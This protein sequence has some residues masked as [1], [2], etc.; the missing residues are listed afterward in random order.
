MAKDPMR[1]IHEDLQQMNAHLK[2]IAHFLQ[3]ISKQAMAAENNAADIRNAF[4]AAKNLNE[5]LGRLK[6]S[7]E[8][9]SV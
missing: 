1:E 2:G 5:D 4:D 8:N 6:D 3:V 7:N 9:Q